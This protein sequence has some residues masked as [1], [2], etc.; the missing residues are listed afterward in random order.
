M[1]QRMKRLLA[2]IM[3]ILLVVQLMP[4]TA[5]A[6]TTINTEQ[7]ISTDSAEDYEI[8]SGGELVIEEGVTVTGNI[9]SKDSVSDAGGRVDNRGTISSSFIMSGL[10]VKTSGYIEDGLVSNS[11]KSLMIQPDATF[12]LLN[13]E[14]AIAGQV[15]TTNNFVV[16]NL[17][18][19]PAAFDPGTVTTINI[20]NGLSIV[21]DTNLPSS[22][23]LSIDDS[24]RIDNRTTAVTTE[25]LCNGLHYEIPAVLFESKTLED[26]YKYTVSDSTVVFDVAEYGYDTAPTKSYTISNTGLADIFLGFPADGDI[27]DNFDVTMDGVTIENREDIILTP[28]SVAAITIAPKTKLAVGEYAGN[29]TFKLQTGYGDVFAEETIHASF[30]V[31][32]ASG[33]GSVKV[34]DVYYGGEVSATVASDTNGTKNVT[35]EYKEKGAADDTYSKEKPSAVGDYVAR[36]IFAE[37]DMYKEVTATTEFSII[38]LPAPKNPYTIEGTEGKNNF[39][40]TDVVIKPAKGYL[41]SKSLDGEYADEIKY[42]KSVASGKIYLKKKS[43]GEKTDAIALEE[44][45][46]DKSQPKFTNATHNKTYYV[47]S[48]QV[49]IEDDNLYKVTL[50]GKDV[51]L[52]GTKV[53]FKLKSNR[54]MEVYTISAEDLAGNKAVRRL[55]IATEWMESNKIAPG[56]SLKLYKNQAYTLDEGTWKVS[57]DSTNYAGGIQF[58]VNT[59]GEYTFEKVSE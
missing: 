49:T 3:T 46:L 24:V 21:G 10:N 51:E 11:T 15:S 8:T 39:F 18:L 43:T 6:V 28:G 30:Q 53:A 54:G 41:I 17:I 13:L 45:L 42:Q 34:E 40:T 31:G 56:E 36:A 50:N 37:N 19:N 47:E 2:I 4:L 44:I 38:Y 33:I 32:K 55:V 27:F 7:Y 48:H 25:V 9:Q 20:T 12:G 59:E 1:K 16:K 14:S 57:G 29:A 5:F 23:V 35:L 52:D 26:I 22:I 58:Y